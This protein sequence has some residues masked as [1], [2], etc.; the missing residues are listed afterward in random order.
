[1]VI[2]HNMNAANATRQLGITANLITK[3]QEKLAS[4]YKINRAADDAAGLSISEKMRRMI[5]GLDQGL[6]NTSDGISYIQ[7][8]DGAME[9]VHS[10]IHRLQELA[11]QSANGTNSESDR[12]AINNEVI[13]IKKEIDR[14]GITSKFNDQ[15]I[16]EQKIDAPSINI[17]GQ[18]YTVEKM[19]VFN[20]GFD[21]NTGKYTYGGI[22]FEDE[23]ISWDEIDPNM[24]KYHEDG[25]MTF[26]G[27][28]YY[29]A[30]NGVQYN[31]ICQDGDAVPKFVKE[32]YFYGDLDSIYVNGN[33]YNWSSFTNSS[34]QALSIYTIDSGRWTNEGTGD[35]IDLNVRR[36]AWNY[37][38][39]G[40]VFDAANAGLFTMPEITINSTWTGANKVQ[41]M[42]SSKYTKTNIT[43]VNNVIYLINNI[44]QYG[45]VNYKLRA[46]KT[47]EGPTTDNPDAEVVHNG[48]WL[49]QWTGDKWEEINGTLLTWKEVGLDDENSVFWKSGFDVSNLV[50]TNKTLLF[51]DP[52]NT[53]LSVSF[54]LKAATTSLDS[55]IDGLDGIII[56]CNQ[57]TTSYAASYAKSSSNISNVTV[58]TSNDIMSPENEL[59][60]GRDYSQ[61]TDYDVTNSTLELNSS[62]TVVSLDFGTTKPAITL[63][64]AVGD[65][66]TNLYDSIEI[67]AK[68]LASG[69]HKEII[70]FTDLIGEGNYTATGAQTE[71]YM[72]N[73]ADGWRVSDGL[74]HA[75]GGSPL[76]DMSS[77]GCAHIDFANVTDLTYLRNCGFDATCGY[78]E[79]HYC[80]LFTLNEDEDYETLIDS[81]GNALKYHIDVIPD[82]QYNSPYRGHFQ[83]QIDLKSLINAGYTGTDIPNALVDL[84]SGNYGF[85]DEHPQGVVDGLDF[86]LTQYAS[87]GSTFYIMNNTAIGHSNPNA[88]FSMKPYEEFVPATSQDFKFDFKGNNEEGIKLTFNYDFSYLENLIH[89]D[90]PNLQDIIDTAFQTAIDD[91][92]SN[93]KMVLSA[94]DYTKSVWKHV[95]NQ[96]N[97]TSSYFNTSINVRSTFEQKY[98]KIQHSGELRDCTYIPKLTMNSFVL[99]LY[100]ADCSTEEKATNTIKLLDIALSAVSKRRSL[101]G[102]IQNRLEH[103]YNNR[104]NSM[105]NLTNSESRIRDTDMA[106]EMVKYTSA[107]V[108]AQASQAIIAQ[109]NHGNDYII[110]LLTQ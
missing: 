75:S 99:G 5:R 21:D 105:E 13:Q 30:R 39:L 35:Y 31:I 66:L 24:V 74:N 37:A 19:D 103:T 67:Y 23:R 96:S 6:R 58:S 14:I 49:E 57:I 51:T 45:Q 17:T 94:T 36:T 56:D 15:Y 41:A 91:I 97:A 7:I 46:G 82:E 79:N 88:I 4:G 80:V 54:S 25:S 73:F 68:Y 107:N 53:T 104:A 38:S 27:G 76:Q 77:Y 64:A 106:E 83:M 32:N 108:I 86:H 71:V 34:G 26:V 29:F 110:G 52:D 33:K 11:V 1:M 92:F 8:A 95:L 22:I 84:L 55:V 12:Q 100:R 16:F 40:D 2:Q 70:S 44:N 61:Q 18:Y 72:V 48:V 78:C 60:L 69:K 62:S 47:E 102:A 109:A 81:N 90:E 50:S 63:S 28:E 89:L 10:M 65:Q 59:D 93:S 9:E 42:S 85:Y 98:V 3:S 43:D 101:Y 87:H 20:A